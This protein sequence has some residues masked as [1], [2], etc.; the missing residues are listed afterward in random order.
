[1]LNVCNCSTLAALARASDIGNALD[2]IEVDYRVRFRSSP[3]SKSEK[4]KPDLIKHEK[5]S[6]RLGL[7][8]CLVSK[9]LYRYNIEV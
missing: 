1:M 6:G 7:S 9:L 4:K 2:I 8:S 5:K 3:A